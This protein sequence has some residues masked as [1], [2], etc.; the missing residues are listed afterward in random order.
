MEQGSRR[1][2][3]HRFS[4]THVVRKQRPAPE[5]QVQHPVLL[6]GVEVRAK[7]GEGPVPGSQLGHEPLLLPVYGFCMLQVIHEGCNVRVNEH[8]LPQ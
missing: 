7:H 4:Q 2:G 5:G 8:P 1:D 3:L 6:K